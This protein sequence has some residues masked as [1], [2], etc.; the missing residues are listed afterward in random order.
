MH[1]A[2]LRGTMWHM[3]T[4]SPVFP[5]P[6]AT[7]SPERPRASR[8]PLVRLERHRI[9]TPAG[10]TVGIAMAGTGMPIVVAHGFGAQGILYAQTLSR[11]VSM[12]FM[13]VAIDMPGHGQTPLPPFPA[14]DLDGYRDEFTAALEVLGI[15]RAV[16]L[17]HSM[18]GRMV[19]EVGALRSE[20]VVALVLVDPV[21]GPWWDQQMRSVTHAPTAW[22]PLVLRLA[23]DAASLVDP[24]D[25]DQTSRI[26]SILVRNS[27]GPSVPLRL[28]AP[29]A[30][31]VGARASEPK[32]ARLAA[33]GV[34]SFV[35]HGS[36]DRPVPLECARQAA[37]ALRAQLVVV[38]GGRHSWLLSDPETLPAIVGNLLGGSLG[39]AWALGV[40]QAGLDP[41]VATLDEVQSAM[42][43]PNSMAGYLSR[44]VEFIAAGTKKPPRYRWA[45]AEEDSGGRAA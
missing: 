22:A 21:V 8:F 26:L 17:G 18:G 6:V 32:L 41:S 33:A 39:D 4:S 19:V 5:R 45:L 11:L 34:P 44:T 1:A 14:L 42:L 27:L 7:P 15:R 20:Q 12:G 28:L 23:A 24:H 29:A 13:V 30:A 40:E 31:L 37:A 38:E 10:R 35:I 16:F 36:Q 9:R 2:P 25:L 43:A 3:S